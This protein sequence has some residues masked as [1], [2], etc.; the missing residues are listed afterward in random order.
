MKRVSYVTSWNTIGRFEA[1]ER[2]KDRE[3]VFS[4]FKGE[5]L[6]KAKEGFRTLL[7][8]GLRSITLHTKGAAWE[9][10]TGWKFFFFVFVPSS[11]LWLFSFVRVSCLIHLN[12][13]VGNDQKWSQMASSWRPT[14]CARVHDSGISEERWS[15]LTLRCGAPQSGVRIYTLVITFIKPKACSIFGARIYASNT[16][17]YNIY[18]VASKQLE[19]NLQ[20]RNG[21]IWNK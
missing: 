7:M 11:R 16:V 1:L 14:R 19:Y 17:L 6:K 4:D 5:L 8:E 18:T 9:G 10:E 12:R 21:I 13:C 15:S 20:A 2:D 3:R